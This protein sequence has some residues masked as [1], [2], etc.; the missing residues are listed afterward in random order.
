MPPPCF[1]PRS[2]D[3]SFE[4][5]VLAS[6]VLLERSDQRVFDESVWDSTVTEVINA[7]EQVRKI[8]PSAIAVHPSYP[9][10]RYQ[11]I[12]IVLRGPLTGGAKWF[13]YSLMPNTGLADFDALSAELGFQA[14]RTETP[15]NGERIRVTVCLNQRTNP[16]AAIEAYKT[17]PSVEEAISVVDGSGAGDWPG[18]IDR[19]ADH[20]G[21][22][23]L[24]AESGI[25][26][27]NRLHE[28]P[29]QKLT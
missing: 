20:W 25:I 10:F 23:H 2:E 1:V 14:L 4:A 12:Q 21:N 16:R 15:E 5:T 19:D 7:L 9:L 6:E 3:V 18:R 27:H 8:L 26:L 29:V 11:Q 17:L 24:P 28:I 13:K 22:R